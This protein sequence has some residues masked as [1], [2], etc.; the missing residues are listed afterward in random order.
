MAKT[1]LLGFLA[2]LF[3]GA[4]AQG[5]T[6]RPL[7][8]GNGKDLIATACTACHAI[9][10]ITDTGHT[11]ADWKLLVERMVAAGAEVPKN[12]IPVV[13]EYLTKNF[14]EGDVPKAV[15]IDQIHINVLAPGGLART[16]Y[17]RISRRVNDSR[18]QAALRRA[19]R[20]VFRRSPTLRKARC[21]LT[22]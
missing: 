9:T 22:R 1:I 21:T 16:D 6:G 19:V 8:A 18:F 15:L 2:A 10:L 14:P 20:E 11:P 5:Q 3:F 17:D 13:T 12:Q 4:A 7:P